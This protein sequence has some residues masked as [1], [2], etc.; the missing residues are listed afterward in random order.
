[1]L[2]RENNVTSRNFRSRQAEVFGIADKGGRVT[3]RRRNKPAYMLVPVDDG[4]LEL[5]AEALCRVEES[6]R[7]YEK[8]KSTRCSMP[9]EV[10]AHL[11]KL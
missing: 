3:I 9:E 11:E 1:M 5:S 4:D 7:E 2:E 6:R 10:I 8:G